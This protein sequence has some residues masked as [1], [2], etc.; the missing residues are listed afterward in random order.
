MGAC[1]TRDQGNG[2]PAVNLYQPTLRINPGDSYIH[3]HLN[4]KS[5]LIYFSDKD[6]QQEC[7]Q[8][9][10]NIS[11]WAHRQLLDEM[12]NNLHDPVVLPYPG[13]GDL[14]SGVP[15]VSRCM[16]RLEC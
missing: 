5:H 13:R 15:S 12:I 6:F 8:S 4:L 9:K 16:V 2:A 14:M 7:I 1:Y 3:T 10:I 11:V